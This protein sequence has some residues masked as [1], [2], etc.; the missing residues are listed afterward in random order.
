M[1][2]FTI[3]ELCRSNTADKFLIDNKCT[4]EQAANMMALVN[5]VLDPL[6]E[7]YGKPIRVNSGFRCE[8]LNKK[9]G[10]SKTSDHLHGMAADITAGIPKE[11]KRLFYL[12]QELGLPFK[13]LIDEKGFSWVHVSY[14]ANNL[15]RQILAL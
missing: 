6:R 14:D 1:K 13:Q 10:G 11:N 3:A 5:N 4:K 15:K 7:A 2:Y 12:I 8:K 9:V